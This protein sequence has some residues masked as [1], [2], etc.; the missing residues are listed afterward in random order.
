VGS[1]PVFYGNNNSRRCLTKQALQECWWWCRYFDTGSIKPGVIGGSKPKVA[2]PDVVKSILYYKRHSAS[3]F[4]WEIRERLLKDA[5][6]TAE[7]L[8]SVSS[9]NRSAILSSPAW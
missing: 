6:C 3:M 7:S 5:I 2:T 9:V 4:A 8:P 1:K